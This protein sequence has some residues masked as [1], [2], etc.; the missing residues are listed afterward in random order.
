MGHGMFVIPWWGKVI[1]AP[2]FAY[3]W[4]NDLFRKDDRKDDNSKKEDGQQQGPL[5]PQ[6]PTRGG[7]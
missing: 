3:W 2:V 1:L 7:A 4:V 5:D 6:D